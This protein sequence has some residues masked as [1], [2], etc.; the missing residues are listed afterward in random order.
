MKKNLKGIY[1]ALVLGAIFLTPSLQA[2]EVSL[3]H[4][5][6]E[7]SSRSVHT[8]TAS[9]ELYPESN[10]FQNTLD[11]VLVEQNTVHSSKLGSVYPY[12][13]ASTNSFVSSHFKVIAIVKDLI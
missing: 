13:I 9:P 6:L 12:A 5:I 10:A 7:F 3:D 2:S 11:N 4:E 8:T 1:K